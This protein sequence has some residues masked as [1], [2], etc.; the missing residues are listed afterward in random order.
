[1]SHKG[2]KRHF[3]EKEIGSLIQ[4]AS[5]LHEE[6]A[7]S[8]DPNLSLKD[9][10]Q[11]AVELG[12]SPEYVRRA[13]LELDHKAEPLSKFSITG[14]PFMVDLARVVPEPMSDEQW[15]FVVAE[16]RRVAGGKGTL[17]SIG[18]TREWSKTVDDL[19][20]TLY[21]MRVSARSDGE[22]TSI[23]L[24]K[25]F[26][27][28]AFL[29]YFFTLFFGVLGSVIFLDEVSQMSALLN[30]FAL[31][32]SVTGIFSMVRFGIHLWSRR[33]KATLMRIADRIQQTI[34]RHAPEVAN[35]HQVESTDQLEIGESDR[36]QVR[37][38]DAAKAVVSDLLKIPDNES[39]GSSDAEQ[40]QRTRS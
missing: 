2:R 37:A 38:A 19:G 1:M 5:E 30:T 33:Q 36:L 34:S 27:G 9:A 8:S 16:L 26:G 35:D 25:H 39:T 21:G 18:Q 17:D 4:R 20:T 32:A 7:G 22:Q 15:E 12:I 6:A 28:L 29:S 40:K 31:A 10:E 13:A 14:A 23:H 24:K 11:I 3:N